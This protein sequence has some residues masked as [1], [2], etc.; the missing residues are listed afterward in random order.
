MPIV[1][2]SKWVKNMRR[3]K[4]WNQAKLQ[5]ELA[6]LF[7]VDINV[8]LT[9]V[10]KGELH[11]RMPTLRNIG[12]ALSVTI[13]EYICP[14]L[15]N[16]TVETYQLRY[17]LKSALSQ[18]D[19]ATAKE[20]IKKLHLILNQKSKVNRQFYVSCKAQLMFLQ[21]SPCAA[22]IPLINEGLLLT[23]HKVDVKNFGGNF[24]A[25]EEPS[26]LY[27]LARVHAREGAVAAAIAILDD[28]H[29][30]IINL[31]VYNHET[32]TLLTQVLLSL[33]EYQLQSNEYGLAL[34]SCEQ[35]LHYR[36]KALN[37]LGRANRLGI[38]FDTFGVDELE[39]DNRGFVY[40]KRGE[41]LSCTGIAD[42]VKTI[43]EQLGYS[44]KDL[45]EGLCSKGNLVCC[46]K[47]IY[48]CVP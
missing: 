37:V 3:R 6:T 22:L 26:L 18:G 27:L 42:I 4:G 16:Q 36:D 11:P 14:L 31:P 24:L 45:Y 5:T 35:G 2:S 44:Q 43:R 10:E 12:H 8:S 29:N 38:S 23:H 7:E 28:L 47:W 13:E 17:D 21:G 32:D 15:D 34:E 41:I 46:K 20:L 40:Y 19:V 9:R 33:C 1:N 25:Y 30:A 48:T 39:Y